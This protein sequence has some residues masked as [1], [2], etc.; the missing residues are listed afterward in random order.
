MSE[1]LE[2]GKKIYF[3]SDAHLGL[4][5]HQK[6][7]EREKLLVKWLDEISGDAQAIYLMGDIFD[8][9]FEYKK[10][11]PRGFVRFLGKLAEITDSGIPVYFFTGNHDVWAFDYLPSE[12]GVTV[13]RQPQH[14]TFNG[15]KFY[16][17]HGDGLGP[18]EWSYKLLK[19]IFTSRFLQ[20]MFARIHP[21]SATGFAHR[22]SKHSRFSK[23]NFVSFLGE[24][25]EHLI[26]H[27]KTMLSEEHFDFFIYGHRHIPIDWKL[28]ESSRVIYLGDWFV[29][30]TYAVFDGE[31]IRLLKYGEDPVR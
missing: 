14:R 1:K 30:F 17:A 8:Y 7:L 24:E 25:K 20:W 2:K 6:S 12:L 15:K 27:S 26:Q 4:P 13:Y 3:V 23:G 29:N 28:N 22:W 18:S 10:V 31:D 9:W 16:L 19:G 11:V 5:P 21:N